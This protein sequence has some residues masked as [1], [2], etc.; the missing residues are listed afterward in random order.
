M[1]IR[2]RTCGARHM[3]APEG[4][5]DLTGATVAE[6]PDCRRDRDL[7]EV[8][9]R[10]TKMQRVRGNTGHPGPLFDDQPNLL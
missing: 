3:T 2:C 5:L 8:R 7:I 10:Q 1:A 9:Q 6:C 4:D